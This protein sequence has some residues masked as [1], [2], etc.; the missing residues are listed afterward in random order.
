[1]TFNFIGI[2]DI[3]VIRAD[4]L[5]MGQEPRERAIAT[6]HT[7]FAEMFRRAA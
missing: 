1:V 5:A 2:T 4:G 7:Q 6:A 3:S